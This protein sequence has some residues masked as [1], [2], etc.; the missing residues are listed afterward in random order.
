[1]DGMADGIR[2]ALIDGHSGRLTKSLEVK[3]WE[4][5]L[6]YSFTMKCSSG[7]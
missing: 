6:V 1:M 4:Q 7:S 2:L 3:C 5:I